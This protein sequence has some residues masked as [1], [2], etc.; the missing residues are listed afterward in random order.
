MAGLG[1]PFGVE[2][3]MMS[4]RAASSPIREFLTGVKST[5]TEW[6]CAAPRLR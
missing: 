1:H 5:V 4:K 2:S 3:M 6:A